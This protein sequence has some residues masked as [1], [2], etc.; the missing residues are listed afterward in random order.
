VS[1]ANDIF[2]NAELGNGMYID[3]LNLNPA[4]NNQRQANDSLDYPSANQFTTNNPGIFGTY[5]QRI[6]NDTTLTS[7]SIVAK[8]I[9]N[10]GS[11][12]VLDGNGV[13]Y[14]A[15]VWVVPEP[16]SGVLTALALAGGALATRRR[17]KTLENRVAKSQVPNGNNNG[18]YMNRGSRRS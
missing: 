2:Y 14:N 12:K 4:P 17:R 7:T 8:V 9:T 11:F 16:T 6:A 1:S 3:K 10:P 18:N 15:A 13:Q 5:W